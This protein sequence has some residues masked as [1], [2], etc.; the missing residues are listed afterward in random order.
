MEPPTPPDALLQ[1][2]LDKRFFDSVQASTGALM[3]S[4]AVSKLARIDILS[5]CGKLGKMTCFLTSTPEVDNSYL[6][7]I[8]AGPPG[9]AR[10]G[11]PIA[12]FSVRRLWVGQ[13]PGLMGMYHMYFRKILYNILLGWDDTEHKCL[14]AG[15]ILGHVR[16]YFCV[17]DE[18]ARKWLHDH[19][20]IWLH[21]HDN[22]IWRLQ[23]PGAVQKLEA[24]INGIISCFIPWPQPYD[25]LANAC[26]APCGAPLVPTEDFDDARKCVRHKIPNDPP[27]LICTGN[28]IGTRTPS[29]KYRRI[30]FNSTHMVAH[31]LALGIIAYLWAASSELISIFQHNPHFR[32]EAQGWLESAGER[33]PGARL[34]SNGSQRRS[35]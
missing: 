5:Y 27:I 25:A 34:V 13:Y 6:I 24:Y 21:G 23:Q 28:S 11:G 20:A 30:I 14:R 31:I 18:Q 29:S 35:I 19:I 10:E 15:G 22:Y 4:P 9:V 8:W 17:G 16:A 7:S 12:S 2:G 33:Y 32:H 26:P 1:S 3:V